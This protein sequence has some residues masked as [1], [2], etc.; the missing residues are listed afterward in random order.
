MKLDGKNKHS[1]RYMADIIGTDPLPL[2]ELEGETGNL[3]KRKN[4][5][6]FI[7]RIGDRILLKFDI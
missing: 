3:G 7:L 6:I 4:G 2:G 1:S 5:G